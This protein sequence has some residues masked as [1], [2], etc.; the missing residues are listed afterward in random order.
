MYGICIEA[1]VYRYM[2]I[3]VCIQVLGNFLLWGD[4]NIVHMMDSEKQAQSI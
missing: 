1:Y 4:V 3:G 2:C